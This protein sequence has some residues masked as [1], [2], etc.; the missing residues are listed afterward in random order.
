[1]RTGAAVVND[2]R[3]KGYRYEHTARP[4]RE[5]DP[6]FTPDLTPQEM[7]RLGV[8]CGKYNDG[9]AW[10]IRPELVCARQARKGQARL[11]IE[12]LRCRR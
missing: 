8:F 1:M 4:G 5:F 2:R 10:R 9:H 11:Q 3:Q 7:L 12:L 6:G